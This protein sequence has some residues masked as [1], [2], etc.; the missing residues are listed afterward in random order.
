[1]TVFHFNEDK[2]KKMPIAVYIQLQ[3][4]LIWLEQLTASFLST[5]L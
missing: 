2:K 3:K 4:R 1:M 5:T